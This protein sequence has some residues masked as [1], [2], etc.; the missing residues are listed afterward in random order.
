M[1]PTPIMSE[2][3]DLSEASR[4]CVR[5]PS[6]RFE[7]RGYLRLSKEDSNEEDGAARKQSARMPAFELPVRRKKSSGKS[8]E[9]V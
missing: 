7:T 6:A 4:P 5:P 8:R 1:P 9:P 3:L 2:T